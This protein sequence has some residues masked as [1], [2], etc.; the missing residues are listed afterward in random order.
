MADDL[1][2]SGVG[3]FAVEGN[4][5]QDDDWRLAASMLKNEAQSRYVNGAAQIDRPRQA[6]P[7]EY[8]SGWWFVLRVWSITVSLACP[9]KGEKQLQ[10]EA[11]IVIERPC[12][13]TQH[14]PRHGHGQRP[15]AF[16]FPVFLLPKIRNSLARS[17]PSIHT[18]RCSH[19]A[20][21]P[22][23]TLRLLPVSL[24]APFKPFRHPASITSQYPL[25][26]SKTP[27]D[28][29]HLRVCE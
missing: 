9:T 23:L 14:T 21:S 25:T 12:A 3:L 20:S 27:L 24:F 5:E 8:M 22:L 10:N 17:S 28:S 4:G 19:S 29:H 1:E 2:Q 16:A 7:G 15:L 13:P 11:S 26:T 6:L 18:H